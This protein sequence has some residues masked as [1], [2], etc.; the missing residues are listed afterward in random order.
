MSQKIGIFPASGGLGTSII[1]HLVKL[2]PASQLIL[3]ARNPEKLASFSR[4]GATIRRADYD[5]RASLERVFDG[6]GVLMLIS[7]ASFEIQHR[8]EAHKAAI[9]AARRSGVKHIFYSS[10]AFAGDL[11]ESSLAHVMGAHLATEKYLA[12]LPGHF[13]YTAIREGLY[14]ESF[15]IYTAWF[16]PHQPVE[17]I[18]IPHP[19]TGPG[20]AWAKR[21][22]LGEATAKMIYAYAKNTAGFPYLNRVVLLSGPREVSLAETAEVLGRAVGKPVRIR[23]ISVDEYVALPQIGDKHTYH[24]LN[25]SREWATA[26]AA[27][28]A[29]ETAVVSP[30]LGE[31]L[32]REP[33]DFETTIRALVG[34]R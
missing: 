17:E 33:E 6:V 2:V 3:I 23:E 14:S 1:N 18:T 15:P 28:R 8:V 30:L 32:G 24:G 16:D 9:D 13:T 34:A 25:L 26:W 27:I 20:V 29:G 5:D 12:E 22:E 31:I 11:G 4:D 10:L 7:Y 19:G 21:D